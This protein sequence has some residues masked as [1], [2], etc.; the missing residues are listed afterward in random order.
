MLAKTALIFVSPV[1]SPGQVKIGGF[2]ITWDDRNNYS[3]R[4]KAVICSLLM[5][6]ANSSKNAVLPLRNLRSIR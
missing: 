3:R 4:L 2:L 5:T 6:S 1:V